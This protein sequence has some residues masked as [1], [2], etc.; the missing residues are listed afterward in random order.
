MEA[1]ARKRYLELLAQYHAAIA[2]PPT[3]DLASM[4]DRCNR[5][6]RLSQQMCKLVRGNP[7]DRIPHPDVIEANQLQRPW[8]EAR[9]K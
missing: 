3:T 1:P 2:E 4:L 9:I 7:N 6:E 8:Y 5:I